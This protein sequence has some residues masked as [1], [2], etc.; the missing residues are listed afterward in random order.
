MICYTHLSKILE[1]TDK[2]R[3]VFITHRG[4]VTH[5]CVGKLTIIGWDNGLSPVRRLAI[6]WTNA[7]ILLTGPIGTNFIEI[8]IEIRTY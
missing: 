5:T 1:E 4:R 7:E 8:L 2:K 6:I 3:L